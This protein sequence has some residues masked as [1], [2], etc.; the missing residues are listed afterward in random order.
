M[1]SLRHLL[2]IAYLFVGVTGALSIVVAEQPTV[3][4]GSAGVLF[5][6]AVERWSS[7][8]EQLVRGFIKAEAFR[9]RLLKPTATHET[10]VGAVADLVSD[11][12]KQTRPG[13]ESLSP[14]RQNVQAFDVSG[15]RLIAQVRG[16]NDLSPDVFDSFDGRWFGRWDQMHVNHEW[17][18]SDRYSPPKSIASQQPSIES[19][20]YAWVGNGFGWNYLS[21]RDGNA[22]HNYILGMV[23]YFSGSNYH[24]ITEEKPHVGFADGPTRLIWITESEIY[25]E[26]AFPHSLTGDPD[27]YVITGLRHDLFGE[28]PSV[29]PTAVQATYTRDPENRPSFQQIIWK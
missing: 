6:S 18:P 29:F 11:F 9:E 14:L 28:S 5:P 16:D 7:A 17:R 23:Y 3:E 25:L 2:S 24:D 27:H 15:D 21:A 1:I 20:Q 13:E 26:E 8:E 22:K 10:G 19:L 4:L 12:Q